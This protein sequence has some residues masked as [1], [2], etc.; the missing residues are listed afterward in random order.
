MP[1][2]IGKLASHQTLS[3]FFFKC[4]SRL[5]VS[6]EGC[7][8]NWARLRPIRTSKVTGQGILSPNNVAPFSSNMKLLFLGI[9][10]LFVFFP[11]KSWPL[12]IC[13]ISKRVS[14]PSYFVFQSIMPGCHQ[15]PLYFFSSEFVSKTS[16]LYWKMNN[17]ICGWRVG[18][19]VN[20]ELARNTDI[21]GLVT[22]EV[23]CEPICKGQ[24]QAHIL[25]VTNPEDTP[26]LN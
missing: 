9:P 11:S 21:E 1:L 3:I 20:A 25:A 15:D 23:G 19:F 4:F 10:H 6:I 12:G 7:E 2:Y 14:S 24:A 22:N 18:K 17:P 8:W 5:V 26:Q 16:K 13:S